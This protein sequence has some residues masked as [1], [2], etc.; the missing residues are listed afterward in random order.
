MS[1]YLDDLRRW[2]GTYRWLYLDKKGLVTTG[3]G[4]L[5]RDLQAAQRLPWFISGRAASADEIRDDYQAVRACTIGLTADAF[6]T[7][8]RCRM[9]VRAAVELAERRLE[10][11][12]LPGLRLYT[13]GFEQ[14]PQQARRALVDRAYCLGLTGLRE[15]EHLQAAVETHDW[16]TAARECH[17]DGGRESRNAWAAALFHEL[18]E[19]APAT[20]R[21]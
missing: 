20:H 14:L 6:E 4:N 9:T 2:E 13:R 1:E 16:A 21:A 12:F 8:T 15:F 10:H 19:G 7:K 17:I 18:A 3:I 11:E 5:V